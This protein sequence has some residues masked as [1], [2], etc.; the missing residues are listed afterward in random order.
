MRLEATNPKLPLDERYFSW[1]YNKVA[2]VGERRPSK[3]YWSLFFVLYT[4]PFEWFVPND[5]NRAADGTNLR[6]EYLNDED[7]NELW[8]SEDCSMFEMLI[9]LAR[10]INFVIQEPTD[11]CFW[12]LL[13]NLGIGKDLTDDVFTEVDEEIVLDIV[14]TVIE[15][16]YD[17]D[18][19]GGLFPLRNPSR[20]Q[21]G[22]EIW[23]QMSAYLLENDTLY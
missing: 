3:T 18:G 11:D 13:R 17:Y 5:H 10:R 2:S 12:L 8:I 19:T 9:G 23:Y 15:R 16:T 21:R 20:D 7:A 14:R 6:L 22:V 1:L 4:T